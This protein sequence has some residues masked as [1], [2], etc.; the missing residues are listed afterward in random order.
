MADESARRARPELTLERR[1]RA[2]VEDVWD[3]WT[4]KEGFES[5]WGPQG[6]RAEVRVLEAREGGVLEYEM[7]ADSHEMIAAMT[8]MGQPLSHG[9]RARFAQLR[10]HERLV[11]S[12]VIDFL[13]GVEPYTSEIAV[14][15]RVEGD[16]VHMTVTLSPMHDAQFTEMQ[17]DGFTSRLTK[18]DARLA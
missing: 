11:L 13:P 5:W 16:S 1:Y 15:L 7:V 3:L 17:K 10:Q 8:R 2:R 14:D 6:F 4:T 18:L 12:S 9:V